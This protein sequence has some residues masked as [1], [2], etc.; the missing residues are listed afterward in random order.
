[1]SLSLAL[2]W[3]GLGGLLAGGQ[4]QAPRAVP[5]CVAAASPQGQGLQGLDQ[6]RP[7]R[8]SDLAPQSGSQSLV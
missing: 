8:Q 1:M 7:T 2:R 3:V 4:A 6:C 5:V